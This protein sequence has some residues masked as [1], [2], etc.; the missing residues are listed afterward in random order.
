MEAS[1]L[2]WERLSRLLSWADYSWCWWHRGVHEDQAG[3]VG[4]R[5]RGIGKQQL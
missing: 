5:G 2:F 4:P 1:N 3:G